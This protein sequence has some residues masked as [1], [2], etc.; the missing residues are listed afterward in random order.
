MFLF[1][2]T[3]TIYALKKINICFQ[4]LEL[5]L[6]CLVHVLNEE[7]VPESSLGGYIFYTS[8]MHAQ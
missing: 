8:L 5:F 2:V 1:C 6:V 3:T 4:Q 7:A